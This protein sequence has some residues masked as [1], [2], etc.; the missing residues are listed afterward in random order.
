[1]MSNVSLV[2]GSWRHAFEFVQNNQ[3]DYYSV[4][5]RCGG[6]CCDYGLV[7]YCILWSQYSSCYSFHRLEIWSYRPGIDLKWVQ[8]ALHCKGCSTQLLRSC[9]FWQVTKIRDALSECQ[10]SESMRHLLVTAMDALFSSLLRSR[11]LQKAGG[12]DG[13]PQEI[14]KVIIPGQVW[15][16]QALALS[17]ANAFSRSMVHRLSCNNV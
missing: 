4:S 6:F 16:S 2:S 3:C 5:H 9:S 1:M 12:Y 15:L 10:Q 8:N 14:G 11:V 13:S 17:A 7:I